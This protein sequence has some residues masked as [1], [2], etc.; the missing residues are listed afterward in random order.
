MKKTIIVLLVFLCTNSCADIQLIKEWRN[1]EVAVYFPQKIL[2]TGITSNLKV[3]KKF[4]KQLKTSLEK[5]GI[6]TIS[7]LDFFEPLEI[8][9]SMT[10][11]ELLCLENK[12]IE[13]GFDT[14]LLTKVVGIEDVMKYNDEFYE[15]EKLY[16]K[17]Q[18]DYL[19]NQRIFNSNDYSNS[20]S[21]Y[22]IE[23]TLYCICKTKDRELIWKGS[24]EVI[25]PESLSGAVKDF[26]KLMITALDE[27]NLISPNI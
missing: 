2:V 19:R 11:K 21:I 20:Y 25:E 8:P 6:E 22:H 7:G 4:E 9:K 10:K 15:N 16:Q 3:Q 5:R 24:I 18:D 14:I 13:D 1:P 17:F 27:R 12:L 23:T 26:V